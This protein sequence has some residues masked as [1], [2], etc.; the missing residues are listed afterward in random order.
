MCVQEDIC[1]SDAWEDYSMPEENQDR[2][3]SGANR[4]GQYSCAAPVVVSAGFNI[5][6]YQSNINITGG[7]LLM[8]YLLYGKLTAFMYYR[9]YKPAFT[10]WWHGLPCKVSPALQEQ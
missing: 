8:W 3:P 1:W 7:S 4:R 2:E 6:L 5:N 9:P 10:H